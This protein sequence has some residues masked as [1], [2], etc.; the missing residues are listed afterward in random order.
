MFRRNNYGLAVILMD[1]PSRCNRRL[2]W[3]KQPW[4][5]GCAPLCSQNEA[6]ESSNASFSLQRCAHVGVKHCHETAYKCMQHSMACWDLYKCM[7]IYIRKAKRKIMHKRKWLGLRCVLIALALAVIMPRPAREH[8]PRSAAPD[9]H[10]D[11]SL[12][13]P[14]EHLSAG[15]APSARRRSLPGPGLQNRS[16][17]SVGAAISAPNNRLVQDV[18]ALKGCKVGTIITKL[19]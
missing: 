13:A 12:S 1:N 18:L 17:G 10:R 11:G 7:C 14:L 4:N 15:Q 5:P 19:T 16:G 2:V 9:F 8:H 3:K 6:F